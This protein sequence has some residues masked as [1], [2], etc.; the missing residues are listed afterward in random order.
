MTAAS[1]TLLALASLALGAGLGWMLSQRRSS[2]RLREQREALAQ[3]QSEA[4]TDPLTGLAN[5]KAKWF[6]PSF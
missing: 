5:R 6:K 1:G 2:R 3:A 4:R